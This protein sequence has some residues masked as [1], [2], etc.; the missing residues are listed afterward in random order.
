M[1]GVLAWAS[2]GVPAVGES[3][4]WEGYARIRSVAA[5]TVDVHILQGVFDT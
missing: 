1:S 2:A 3:A 5:F 4:M